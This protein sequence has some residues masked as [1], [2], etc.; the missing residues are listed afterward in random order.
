MM[1]RISIL[2]MAT[3]MLLLAACGKSS[4]PVAEGGSNQQEAEEKQE[5]DLSFKPGD[6]IMKGKVGDGLSYELIASGGENNDMF[7]AQLIISGDG[8]LTFASGGNSHPWDSYAEY[9]STVILEEGITSIGPDALALPNV[10][11]VD[12][13][14]SVAQIDNKAFRGCCCVREFNVPSDSNYFSTSSGVIYNKDMTELVCYPSGSD[15]TSYNILD[16]VSTF[17][18]G[19]YDCNNLVTV[20]AK[21][22][23]LEASSFENCPALEN[24]ISWSIENAAL[25]IRGKGTV[26]ALSV[27]KDYRESIGAL[28]IEEGITRIESGCFHDEYRSVTKLSLPSTLESIGVQAFN[29]DPWHG[30]YYKFATVEI[31]DLASWCSVESEYPNY[32]FEYANENGGVFFNGE[33]MTKLVI[34][35]GVENIGSYAFDHWDINGIQFP[36]SLKVIQPH[37]FADCR[38]TFDQF[39]IPNNI[40]RIGAGA[41]EGDDLNINVLKFEENMPVLENKAFSCFG[42]GHIR[43]NTI[44]I[45]S[46]EQYV[47][48]ATTNDVYPAFFEGE[49]GL[50]RF[51]LAVAGKVVKDI[52]IPEGVEDIPNGLFYA[53]NLDSVTIPKS[54]KSLNVG[55]FSYSHGMIGVQKVFYEGTEDEWRAVNVYGDSFVDDFL[56]LVTCLS[57]SKN[58]VKASDQNGVINRE[59]AK[60]EGIVFPNSTTEEISPET[61]QSLSDEEI[62]YAI[63]ELY[64][65]NGYIFNSEEMLAYYEKYDW[66]EKRVKSEDFTDDLFSD[67]E[68]KNVKALEAEREKRQ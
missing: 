57:G 6:T 38:G 26:S 41:F 45:P 62:R 52:A 8:E 66:Y 16:S 39:V 27:W 55:A 3:L 58:P 44:D 18:G 53:I 61:I 20:T 9:I 23:A 13:P 42:T 40:E 12:L 54:V 34:P 60:E 25:V 14:L 32:F 29:N 11:F 17:N 37:A 7:D 59:G 48:M 22:I 36:E 33:R 49:N 68:L 47:T 56:K 51:D 24:I 10:H 50:S 64:A 28:V 35:E 15:M 30:A 46:V 4:K 67:I 21:D 63:N 1:K 19:F 65:R 5:V 43:I 2:L 31:A